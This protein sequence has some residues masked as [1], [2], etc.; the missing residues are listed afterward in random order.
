MQDNY[1]ESKLLIVR[2]KNGGVEMQNK[3]VL[4]TTVVI[5]V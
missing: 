5:S 4:K 2:N 1:I 3:S